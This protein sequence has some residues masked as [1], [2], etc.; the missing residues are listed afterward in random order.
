MVI[1]LME[2]YNDS[3]NNQFVSNRN[4]KDIVMQNRDTLSGLLREQSA[5]LEKLEKNTERD[6]DQADNIDEWHEVA[7]IMDR[8]FLFLYIFVMVLSSIIFL[9]KMTSDY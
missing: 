5:V 9:A 8:V 1:F 2:D 6:K 7:F 3:A 4:T